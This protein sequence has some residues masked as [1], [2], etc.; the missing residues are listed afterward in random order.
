[1]IYQRIVFKVCLFLFLT[2]SVGLRTERTLAENQVE[3]F[4]G[5]PYGVGRVTVGVLRGQPVLPLSDERFTLAATGGR[6]MYP[7]LKEQSGRRLLRQALQIESP[8]QVTF[9]FL[10][11]GDQPFDLSVFAPQEQGMRVKPLQDRA[12]HSRLMDEWWQQVTEQNRRLQKDPAYPPVVD[13]FLAATF[14]RRL[15]RDIPP[16]KQGLLPWNNK[17]KAGVLEELFLSESFQLRVD[18]DM[19]SH[20][21]PGADVAPMPAPQDWTSPKIVE[22]GLEEVAVEPIAAMVPAECFYLRFGNFTNYLWFRDFNRKWQGDIGNMILRRGIL[23]GGSQRIQQQL[24]LRENVLAKIFGPQ[25]IADAAIIGLDPYVAEGAAIG[26]LFQAKNSLLLSRDLMKQRQAA[27]EK[28][29]EAEEKTIQLI[30][31]DVSFIGTPNGRVRSYYVQWGDFH[32]VT[33]SSTLALR[34]IQAAGGERPLA[35]QPAFLMARQELPL[36][37]DDALFA[38][39]PAE[40]FQNLCSPQYRIETLRRLRSR[41]EAHLLELA[42]YAARVEGIAAFSPTDLVEADLL[43]VGFGLRP[44]DSQLLER[45]EGGFIDTARGTPGYYLPVADLIPSFASATEETEYQKFVERFE[46]EIGQMPPIA[47]GVKRVPHEDTGGESMQVDL[48]VTQLPSSKLGALFDALGEPTNQQLRPVEGD[49]LAA[50]AAVDL[51]VPI[52]GGESQPHHVFGALHD[53]RSPLVVQSG[54]IL[55]GDAPAELVRGYLGAWPKPGILELFVG[56]ARPT[57]NAPER[58]GGQLWQAQQEEFFLISFKPEVIEQVLPQLILEPAERPAQ[59]RLRLTDLTGTQMAHNVN[60]LGYMRSRETSVAASRMMNSLANQ[61]Q[62]PRSECRAVAERLVDG[63]F[64]CALGGEYQLYA[65][66]RGLEVWLSTALPEQN[67]FLLTEVPED[68]QLPLLGWFRG[69]E[70]DLQV[71]EESLRMHLEIDMTAEALP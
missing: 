13:N 26:I 33:T 27:L 35:E 59:V 12:G 14:S 61:L 25:V 69:F 18:Q 37:R 41:R 70:G 17:K 56:S 28:Y 31:H 62:V 52:V 36:D 45:K 51:P 24:S 48:W 53:F 38:F 15:R 42:R 54:A 49:I 16:P 23:R 32:L 46:E 7:V 50:E 68:F 57:G 4:A 47:V 71:T 9:Y 65:P 66:E 10:F 40:F 30:G 20:H 29:P 43:P 21:L 11:P 63:K 60:A 19:L 67:H 39:I 1:M 8:A 2:T 5:Q 55:P 64:T 58:A 6:A 3:A 44:D 34:F 22:P